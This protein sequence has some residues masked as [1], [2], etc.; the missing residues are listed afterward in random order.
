MFEWM[1]NMHLNAIC[2]RLQLVP[3][4]V[5]ALL[6]QMDRD[7]SLPFLH[8]CGGLFGCRRG[9]QA[10]SAMLFSRNLPEMPASL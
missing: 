10:L 6:F 4:R 2:S 8:D 7:K 1:G 3:N 5:M 9:M